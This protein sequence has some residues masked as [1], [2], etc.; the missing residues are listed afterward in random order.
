MAYKYKPLIRVPAMGPKQPPVEKRRVSTKIDDTRI[1]SPP[2]HTYLPQRIPLRRARGRGRC[3]PSV[4]AL[5][6]IT[7]FTAFIAFTCA[8][9]DLYIATI[10]STATDDQQPEIALSTGL[11]HSITS[12]KAGNG[13]SSYTMLTQQVI[14]SR[15]TGKARLQGH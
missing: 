10:M 15:A 2:P 8:T 5:Q 7:L 6:H 4:L 9:D 12:Y 14:L 1:Q 3:Q 13:D 11:L